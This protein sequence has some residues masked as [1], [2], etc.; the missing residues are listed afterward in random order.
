MPR[1]V[2]PHPMPSA[3][4]WRGHTAWPHGR[5]RA[6]VPPSGVW[7]LCSAPSIVLVDAW[8]HGRYN[9]NVENVLDGDLQ[10]QQLLVRA[11]RGAAQCGFGASNLCSKRLRPSASSTLRASYRS[12]WRLVV[13]IDPPGSPESS[14]STTGRCPGLRYT[15]EVGGV[16]LPMW[17][18]LR[19]IVYKVVSSNKV[20]PGTR[21]TGFLQLSYSRLTPSCLPRPS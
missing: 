9:R 12:M 20:R 5:T 4:T 7:R 10:V 11:P 21:L 2:K 16:R 6:A 18:G 15:S 8:C 1:N 3:G 13:S 14:H 17:P 19:P